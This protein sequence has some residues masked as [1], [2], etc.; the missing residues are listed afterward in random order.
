M[1]LVEVFPN[2]QVLETSI[3]FKVKI[4]L[5]ITLNRFKNS[6]IFPSHLSDSMLLEL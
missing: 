2:G 1:I 3:K 4:A 6:E 5:K